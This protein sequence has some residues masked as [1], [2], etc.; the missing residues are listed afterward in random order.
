MENSQM[1]IT[2]K[3]LEMLA[4]LKEGD[5][6]ISF[7]KLGLGDEAWDEKNPTAL[8][9]PVTYLELE[10]IS[11]K[12]NE[13]QVSFYFTNKDISESFIIKEK[14]LFATL[15]K[16][17]V[18]QEEI[19][20]AYANTPEETIVP[21]KDMVISRYENIILALNEASVDITVE[22]AA[23]VT[24]SDF[25]IHDHNSKNSP[26][27]DYN[28]L[29]NTPNSMPADGGNADTVRHITFR[30]N[31]GLLEYKATTDDFWSGVSAPIIKSIQRGTISAQGSTT[32]THDEV[33]MDKSFILLNGGTQTAAFPYIG[34]RTS[35][36]FRI[37]AAFSNVIRHMSWQLVEFC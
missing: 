17:T 34:E 36:T 9:S 16:N 13:V 28:N 11:S 1:T 23:G 10:N 7:T 6:K 19:L 15:I 25:N 37:N 8:K 2:Q 35:T 29:L 3:G 12:D 30:I 21:P 14:G 32:V 27:V 26:A 24:E 5:Y 33:N 18:P 22:I 20:F 31:E 4:T